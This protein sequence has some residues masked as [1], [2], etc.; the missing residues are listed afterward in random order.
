MLEWS[1]INDKTT[2][3]FKVAHLQE[4]FRYFEN[5]DKANYSF[6][7]VNTLVLKH[8]FN[9]RFSEKL[10]LQSVLDYNY[11]DAIGDS[12]GGHNRRTFSATALLKHQPTESLQYGANFRQ[13]VASDF[14]SPFVF[15]LD[16]SYAISQHYALQFNGSKNYRI[17][18]FNDLYWQ[19]GGNLDLVPESS[20][21]LDFGQTFNY[22]FANLKLNGFYITTKD[23]IQ[24]KPNNS[25]IWSP[26]NIAE[27]ENYGVEAELR[28]HIQYQ[29]IKSEIDNWFMCHY[30]KEI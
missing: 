22:K 1:R 3:Q 4:L 5:K 21:G 23:L 15:S 10:Q 18:T 6:G 20:Y 9:F 13:D 26:I 27:A 28:F 29:K 17:P 30:I 16:A 11:I 7:K 14:K 19:P 2:S 12:F 8:N 25:G 24:W